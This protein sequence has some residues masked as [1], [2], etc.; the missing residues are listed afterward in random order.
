MLSVILIISSF[1]A[2]AA[3]DIDK[4]QEL[5]VL[6]CAA[7]YS[8]DYNGVGPA[9]AG[10]FGRKTGTVQNYIYSPALKASG[11]V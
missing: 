9:H 7:C 2:D 5:Y 11:L 3:G 8:V 4:G 6:R 10:V 1:N